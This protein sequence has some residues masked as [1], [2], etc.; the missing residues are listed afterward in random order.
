METEAVQRLSRDLAKAGATMSD[1]EARFLVD[2]YYI[3]QD[4]RKRSNNQIRQ[5]ATE[6]HEILAWF[7]DNSGMLE[8][9]I[10]RALENYTDAQTPVGPWLKANYGIGP[11]ISAGLLAHI[12][13]KQCD[14]VGAIW[15]FAGLDPTLK[16]LPNTKRP[17]NA[18]LK[19]LCWKI[20][21]SFMKFSNAPEC[22]YGAA[23]KARK[24]FEIARNERGDNAGSAA[25]ILA[26][27]KFKRNTEARK[28]YEAGCLPPAQ[29]DGRARRWATKLFLSHLH[30]VWYFAE[31]GRLPPKPYVIERLGHVHFV[32]PQHVELVPGLAE[33]L[34]QKP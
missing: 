21:Q 12:D 34:R 11:V 7:A 22:T 27:K 19:V 5:M 29:V 14:T 24:A 30:L 32:E 25:E 8:R 23:Y 17:W 16:W 10:I 3:L 2:G 13:I 4:S 6:P 33:A 31:F 18:S 26:T 15:R 9:Q 1:E 20:G 28:A